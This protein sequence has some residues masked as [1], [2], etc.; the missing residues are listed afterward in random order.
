MFQESSFFHKDM[1]ALRMFYLN[2]AVSLVEDVTIGEL[3]WLLHQFREQLLKLMARELLG[4]TS[5]MFLLSHSETDE[6][7]VI[8]SV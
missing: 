3:C 4:K 2:P 5:A 6:N 1:E 8:G 7:Q